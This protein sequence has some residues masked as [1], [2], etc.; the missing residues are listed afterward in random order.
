MCCINKH[1]RMEVVVLLLLEETLIRKQMFFFSFF[2]FEC[3]LFSFCLISYSCQFSLIISLSFLPIL[4]MSVFMTLIRFKCV[5]NP[6]C[7]GFFF[8]ADMITW[9]RFDHKR[10]T[11][12]FWLVSKKIKQSYTKTWLSN[13]PLNNPV[14]KVIPRLVQ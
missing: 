10:W 14:I 2:M 8:T 12:L 6:R 13:M 7:S 3:P 1:L 11:P 5:M 4:S 9:L